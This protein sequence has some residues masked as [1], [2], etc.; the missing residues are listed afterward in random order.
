[1][2][3]LSGATSMPMVPPPVVL[4]RASKGIRLAWYGSALPGVTGIC[5]TPWWSCRRPP[6]GSA[7]A[8]SGSKFPS[9]RSCEVENPHPY[10]A[11]PFSL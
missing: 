7:A 9:L 11:Q 1:M 8:F 5:S 10:S 2:E 3:E 4:M 6:T